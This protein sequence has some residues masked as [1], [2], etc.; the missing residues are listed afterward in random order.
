[1]NEEKEKNEPNSFWKKLFDDAI[2]ELKY[3]FADGIT[4]VENEMI[5]TLAAELM[6][7]AM[8]H[9]DQSL[10]KL[11]ALVKTRLNNSFGNFGN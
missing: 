3:A 2:V 11:N 7:H 1:M 5:I 6:A 10:S 8:R 9:N 4:P